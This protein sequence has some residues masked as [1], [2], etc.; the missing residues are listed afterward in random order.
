MLF[1]HFPAV[2]RTGRSHNRHVLT[3]RWFVSYNG[4]F[5]S[6]SGSVTFNLASSRHSAVDC[7]PVTEHHVVFS[8]SQ[9]VWE[10]TERNS[11]DASAVPVYSLSRSLALTLSDGSRR[12]RASPPK[13]FPRLD[14]FLRVEQW[15]E[16]NGA[17][18]KRVPTAFVLL[19]DNTSC[20]YTVSTLI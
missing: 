20:P 10:R 17:R 15:S 11:W 1:M 8:P 6:R 19:R 12:L 18:G 2:R 4:S 16:L 5:G 13:L 3:R 14:G 7:F 9:D